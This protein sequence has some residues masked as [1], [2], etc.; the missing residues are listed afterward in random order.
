VAYNGVSVGWTDN[1]SNETGFKLERSQDGVTFAEIATLGSNATTF[2]DVA[3]SAKSTYYYRVRAYNSYGVSAYS[4][5]LSVTTPDVP[6]APPA[7]P[8]SIAASNNADGSALVNWTDA[9]TNES[10]F[11]VSRETWNS[12]RKVWTSLTTVGTVSANI[13]SMIDVSGAGTF[14]YTVRALNSGGASGYTGPAQ[15]T[16]SVVTSSN[17]KKR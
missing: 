2:S 10:S 1:S 15:V 4:N 5:T 13:T 16:V 9:A 12:K 11:E 3:V 7:T 17:K 8:T 14:R 6:P